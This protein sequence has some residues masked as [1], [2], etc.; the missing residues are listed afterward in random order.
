MSRRIFPYFIITLVLFLSTLVLWAPFLFRFKSVGYI[1]F[2]DSVNMLELY[3]HWDGVLYIIVAKTFYNFKNFAL[4]KLPFDVSAKY[5]AAHYPLYPLL[6][7]VTSY[8]L[9]YLKSML[10]WP[11]VFSV[12]YASFLYFFVKK[13]QLSQKPLT[14]ALVALF[15]T[16]RFFVVRSVPAPETIFMFFILLSIYFFLS[17]KYLLAGCIGALAVLTRSPGILLFVAFVLYFLERLL[18]KDKLKLSW[19]GI[20]LIPLALLGLFLFY[21]RQYNDFFAYFNSGD[22]IHLLFPPFQVFKH[23]AFWVGTAWLEDIYF[24]YFF[25]TL[26]LFNLYKQKKLRPAFYFVLVYFLSIISV[27]HKDI[28]RYSLPMLPFAL[29]SFEKFFTSRKVVLA[30]LILLPALYLYAWNFIVYNQAPIT[31]WKIFQ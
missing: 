26:A 1:F 23:T 27:Q 14:L 21:S 16:P 10:L 11:V 5:F 12:F 6:I 28:A 24:I 2:P 7:R 22:N 31:E 20:I 15:F 4:Q 9:G 30:L 19:L 29:I 3:K 8:L 25:Y 17:E 13:L 18:K